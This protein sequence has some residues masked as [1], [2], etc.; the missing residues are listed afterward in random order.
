[1]PRSPVFAASTSARYATSDASFVLAVDSSCWSCPKVN[2]WPISLQRLGMFANHLRQIC[3]FKNVLENSQFQVN[4]SFPNLLATPT[5]VVWDQEF[6]WM[7]A[8]N[9]ACDQTSSTKVPNP[10]MQVLFNSAA[11][12]ASLAHSF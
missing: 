5:L 3:F 6:S 11:C 8:G 9:K 7:L 4:R 1:M 12:S 10:P 2:A